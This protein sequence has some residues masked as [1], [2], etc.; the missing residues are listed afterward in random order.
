ML[1]NEELTILRGDFYQVLPVEKVKI[2]PLAR[3]GNRRLS[4]IDKTSNPEGY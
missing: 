1:F 4:Y 2:F 3:G